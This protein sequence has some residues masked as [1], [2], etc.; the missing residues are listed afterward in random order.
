MTKE[1]NLQG[2][3]EVR[4]WNLHHLY[5]LSLFV[6]VWASTDRNSEGKRR[7]GMIQH[8]VV[9]TFFF[10]G[11]HTR[12]CIDRTFQFVN[13]QEHACY[14]CFEAFWPSS[15]IFSYW[16]SLLR[17]TWTTVVFL[18]FVFFN[19][20]NGW[21]LKSTCNTRWVMWW[22][23][24]SE[25]HKYL[26]TVWAKIMTLISPFEKPFRIRFQATQLWWIA[27]LHKSMHSQND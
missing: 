15:E 6:S 27:H 4:K 7:S 16:K 1:A 2:K 9:E 5:P 8:K 22:S 3:T 13:G 14:S 10:F 21:R 26:A 11:D 24:Y 17:N 23:R 18:L 19:D 20:G 25:T 12:V